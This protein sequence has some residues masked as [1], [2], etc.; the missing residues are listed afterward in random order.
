MDLSFHNKNPGAVFKGAPY[1]IA[2]TSTIRVDEALAAVRSFI[3]EHCVTPTSKSWRAAGMWPSEHTIRRRL[4]SFRVA[5]VW[6]R[7]S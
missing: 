4:G 6:D 7:R 3:A 1:E 2:E 5:V